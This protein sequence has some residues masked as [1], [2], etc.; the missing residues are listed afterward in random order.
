MTF[1]DQKV[2]LLDEV[3]RLESLLIAF[4]TGGGREDAEYGQLRGNL[5]HN[6]AVRDKLPTFVRQCRN[7]SQFWA[8]LTKQ[9]GTYKERREFLW[10]S[11]APLIDELEFLGRSG[12]TIPIRDALEAFDPD[13]VHVIWEKA[14]SRT[15]SDPEGA[16]TAA[17]TLIETVCKYIL[18]DLNVPYPDDID[19]PK[20]W[21]IAAEALKLAPQQH[22]E[23]ASR[24]SSATFNPL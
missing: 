23:Q 1:T 18:D 15:T 22:E 4:A 13:R 20:L 2:S 8:M 9:Y 11:F 21:A 12:A 3:L 24:R 17:R 16:H 19:L 10:T 6:A 5:V 7:L 14:N